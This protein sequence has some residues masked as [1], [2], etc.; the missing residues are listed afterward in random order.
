MQARAMLDSGL[1]E[2]AMVNQEFEEMYP[3]KI[4]RTQI[5]YNSKVRPVEAC[6]MLLLCS[7]QPSSSCL[8]SYSSTVAIIYMSSGN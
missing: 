2:E 4:Q 3:G 5:A 8:R 1:S 6:H 7:D